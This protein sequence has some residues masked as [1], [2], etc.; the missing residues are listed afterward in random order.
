MAG[1]MKHVINMANSIVGV[2]ILSM[3]FCFREA[4]LLLGVVVVLLSAAITKRTCMFLIRSA[5]MARRRSYEFLAFHVFGV[6]GKLFVELC[7]I[8][9]LIGISISFHV[10][11]GDLAPAIVARAMNLDNSPSLRCTMLVG[12]GLLVVLPL[13]L[14]RKLDS[15]ASMSACSIIFYFFLVTV[16][17]WHAF[18]KLMDG[19]WY[20]MAELWRPAGALQ[21]LPICMLGLSCQSNVFE[22]YDSV[23]DPDVPKMRSVVNQALNLCSALYISVGFFGYIAFV[24]QDMSGNLILN[25]PASEL[26]EGIKIFFTV[27]LAISFP[28]MIFPCRTSINSLLYRRS[29]PSSYD[30]VGNY[31]PESR[32]KGITIAILSISLVIGILIPNIEFVLGLLGSTMGV[33]IALILPSLLFIKVNTKASAERF[34]AQFIML[35]GLLLLVLGTYLNLAH[36][37]QVQVEQIREAPDL[38]P[39]LTKNNIH[40]P[41]LPKI[42]EKVSEVIKEPVHGDSATRREPVAPEPPPDDVKEPP[43][44]SKETEDKA[45][46]EV[47]VKEDSKGEVKA[48]VRAGKE[49]EET[50]HPDA[51]KKEENEGREENEGVEQ[52]Q[53]ELLE[54]IEVQ[55]KEQQQILAEQKQI[56]QELK[57]QKAK[58]EQEQKR[59]EEESKPAIAVVQPVGGPDVNGLAG[60]VRDETVGKVALGNLASGGNVKMLNTEDLNGLGYQNGV[61]IVQQKQQQQQV[62]VVPDQPVV[63]PLQQQVIKTVPGQSVPVPGQGLPLQ[64]VP[65]PVAQVAPGPIPQA[66]PGPVHQAV[67][68]PVPQVAPGPVPQAVPG[69]VHQAVPGPGPVAQAVPG[70]VA[71]VAP[72]QVPQAVPG[73]VPQAVP[74]PVAQAVPGPVAQVAPDQ[75]PQAVPGQVHQAVP[76]P[77]AQ[78][79]PGPVAQAV[80]GQVP[81]A[82]PGQVPQ[83][84][85]G[86]VPQAVPGQV[87]QAV[88]G[89]VPQAVPGQVPQAVP[90]PVAQVVQGQA[91]QIVL[92]QANQFVSGQVAQIAQNQVGQVPPQAGPVIPAQAAPVIPVQPVQALPVHG[93]PAEAQAL[94]LASVQY[95]PGAVQGLSGQ[96]NIVASPAEVR[97]S[98]QAPLNPLPNYPSAGRQADQGHKA[99]PSDINHQQYKTLKEHQN[100]PLEKANQPKKSASQGQ[101]VAGDIPQQSKDRRVSPT[102][103]NKQRDKKQSNKNTVVKKKAKHDEERRKREAGEELIP[104]EDTNLKIGIGVNPEKNP[105]L[106]N[107]DFIEVEFADIEVPKLESPKL[108]LQRVESPIVDVP[109][110]NLLNKDISKAEGQDV[111]YDTRHLLWTGRSRRKKRRND[112]G[113]DDYYW[114]ET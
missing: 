20:Q 60:M 88:P 17:I 55:H 50:L 69:P 96:G 111:A 47:V 106:Q 68:G 87:P 83:A 110:S 21:V 108:D 100:Q 90:G 112:R 11:M 67:P 41:N 1:N 101:Q 53:A 25:F 12:I 54:K 85:P 80:P 37:H 8:L 48:K 63:P 64:A 39:D 78:V 91:G 15:L 35:M 51:I 44:H 82:I 33:L 105:D 77:V 98:Q 23:P 13:C 104:P 59:Q 72:D 34:L 56:L 58:Q 92:G 71:Q 107:K 114:D 24:D 65:G 28:L 70:P 66:V 46:V 79:V 40:L 49:K 22:I 6:S 31:M 52:K 4:G 86:Q 57:D 29:N 7:M 61:P 2:S 27:S 45:A 9:F 109:N 43:A 103:E 16:I 81:Q 73:Q 36:I 99:P 3:P 10:V 89:P 19:S 95:L 84:V 97:V 76:G 102:V 93:G 94:P 62:S 5:I 113:R 32:F 75:V 30:L 26:T 38:S 74:G 42:E 18:P 14:L